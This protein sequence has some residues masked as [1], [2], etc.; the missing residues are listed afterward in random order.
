MSPLC[1]LTPAYHSP[2]AHQGH[3]GV[4]PADSLS[5]MADR[6]ALAWLNCAQV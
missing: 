4:D 6:K 1:Q 5:I 2:L 3:L